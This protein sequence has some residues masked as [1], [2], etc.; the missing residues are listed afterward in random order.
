MPKSLREKFSDQ[1]AI[2]GLSFALVVLVAAIVVFRENISLIPVAFV[3][4]FAAGGLGCVLG[5]LF[6]IPKL[7]DGAGANDPVTEAAVRVASQKL[8]FNTNLGQVSD[9]VTKIVIGL[10][11]AQF[12][13]ILDGA[14]WLGARFS[15]VFDKGLSP[16]AAATFGMGITIAA[17]SF[18][19]ML[20]YLWTT[21]RLPDVWAPQSLDG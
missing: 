17:G 9:W 13:Q 15:Q 21:T 10:G 6:G 4:A 1:L 16:E 2:V 20:A 18:S 5:F 14:Q 11:I 12:G 7:A 3:V 8:L 19:F